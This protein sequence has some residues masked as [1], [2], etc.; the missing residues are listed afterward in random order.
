MSPEQAD[1]QITDQRSDLFSVG[2]VLANLLLGH[3]IFKGENA[4]ESRQRIMKAAIPD[5][6]TLD[7]R[8]DAPLN[9]ILQRCLARNLSQRF[10]TADE[11]MY[12]LEYYIY[13]GGY[14][15]T[16]ET[17]GKFIRELFGP[18]VPPIATQPARGGT[19]LLEHTSRL[20]SKAKTP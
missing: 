12:E 11:L 9:Q 18:A 2:V 10:A 16:N 4:E 20:R 5:F 14:G 1:F 19:E 6:R 15:P 13:H 17:L 3:N 8:I 7:P